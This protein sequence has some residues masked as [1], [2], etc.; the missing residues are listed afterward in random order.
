[1]IS[2]LTFLLGISLTMNIILFI[3]FY[4]LREKKEIDS[5]TVSKE[6]RNSFFN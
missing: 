1:M 6:E 3:I 5:I 4:K 2:I